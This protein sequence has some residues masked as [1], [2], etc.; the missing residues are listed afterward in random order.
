MLRK[1]LTFGT[2]VAITL[3]GLVNVS[4]AQAADCTTGG[5]GTAGD[6]YVICNTTDFNQIAG[7]PAW[8]FKLGADLDFSGYNPPSTDLE[9]ELDGNGKVIRNFSRTIT[10]PYAGLFEYIYANAYIHDLKLENV[11]LEVN[12]GAY[13][14]PFAGILWGR[15]ERI[16]A[17][18]VINTNSQYTA[19]LFAI[20]EGDATLADSLSSVVINRSQ[21]T[22]AYGIAS[23]LDGRDPQ[24][25]GDGIPQVSNSLYLGTLNLNALP[26]YMPWFDHHNGGEFPPQSCDVVSGV[27]SLADDIQPSGYCGVRADFDALGEATAQTEGFTNFDEEV[28]NFGDS[29][30][31]PILRQFAQAPSSPKGLSVTTNDSGLIGQVVPGFDGGS[32]VTGYDVQVRRAG[33]TWRDYSGQFNEPTLFQVY[34]LTTGAYYDV[35]VRAKNALGAGDWLSTT[36]SVIARESAG[37]VQQGNGKILS[38]AT[39]LLENP[40]L[41]QVV[42][43]PSGLRAFAYTDL[44]ASGTSLV[45][46][47]VITTTGRVVYE[48]SAEVLSSLDSQQLVVGDDRLSIAVSPKGTMAI[49]Y[50]VKS[51]VGNNVTTTVKVRQFKS[52]FVLE[53]EIVLAARTSDKTSTACNNDENCGYE[54]IQLV[55]DVSGKFAAIATYPG[56]TGKNLVAAS[57]LGYRNWL[58]ASLEVATAVESTSII[59]GKAGF[60]VGWVNRGATSVAKYSLL[61]KSGTAAWSKAAVIDSQPGTVTGNWVKRSASLASFVWYANLVNSDV[62]KVRDFDLAKFKFPK[63]AAVVTSP[64]NEVRSISA[65]ASQRGE[66]SISWDE[67]DRESNAHVIKSLTLSSANVSGPTSTFGEYVGADYSDLEVASSSNGTPLITWARDTQDGSQIFVAVKNV[68]GFDIRELPGMTPTSTQPR[69]SFLPTGDVLY[70][71]IGKSG[72]KK[73]I[74][75][76]SILSGKAPEL[77][78]DIVLTG[79]AKVGKTLTATFGIWYSHTTVTKQTM[80]WWRCPANFAGELDE[81][82]GCTPIAGATKASYK[83]A[84]ADKGKTLGFTIDATNI[85]GKTSRS[86]A[87]NGTVG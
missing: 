33:G 77:S 23:V 54:N 31:L 15:A 53:E 40:Q 5:A 63:V 87:L 37:E 55:S 17:S 72:T 59:P 20:I 60:L 11:N 84:K 29:T 73:L 49:A 28:W 44:L 6:P 45:G 19:G 46:I 74:E 2:V 13:A 10:S 80:Q 41:S 78:R 69:V 56:A 71:S 26:E 67:K 42:T 61:K 76:N 7:H 30:S 57:Q 50:V 12:N 16:Q 4:A 18:G 82:F 3:S 70:V 52:Q 1:L 51:T 48:G 62:V 9:G 43:L 34:A 75:M 83:A 47:K 68:S 14:A 27:F 35:R 25:G 85:I 86:S 24:D 21:A 38:A 64:T 79:Q 65:S 32:A 36:E 66:L 8:H 58:T 39:G 81:L 22:I